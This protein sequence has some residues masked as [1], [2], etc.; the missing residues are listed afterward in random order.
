MQRFCFTPQI[1]HLY[2]FNRC[3]C[4]LG[5][6]LNGPQDET[7]QDLG[8]LP[9]LLKELGDMDNNFDHSTCNFMPRYQYLL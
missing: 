9:L 5:R 3:G 8:G 2:V 4:Y 6:Q 7:H 1:T